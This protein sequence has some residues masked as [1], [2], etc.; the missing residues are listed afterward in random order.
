VKAHVAAA[1]AK[2]HKTFVDVIRK[3]TGKNIGRIPHTYGTAALP[4]AT[5]KELSA[6]NGLS[7][8]RTM[9]FGGMRS[10]HYVDSKGEHLQFQCQQWLGTVDTNVKYA[11]RKPNW[12]PG[13]RLFNKM[14]SPGAFGGAMYQASRDWQNVSFKHIT[15]TYTSACDGLDRGSIYLQYVADPL[16]PAVDTGADEVSHATTNGQMVTTTVYTE[17]PVSLVVQPEKVVKEL[18]LNDPDPSRFSFGGN[19]YVGV[20]DTVLSNLVLGDIIVTYDVEFTNPI[21]SYTVSDEQELEIAVQFNI[22]A[23]SLGTQALEV[24]FGGDQGWPPPA[25]LNGI[26]NGT[27]PEDGV[28]YLVALR[29]IGY[30]D[31]AT[32]TLYWHTPADPTVYPLDA[33]TVLYGALSSTAVNGAVTWDNNSIFM[34]VYGVASP[35]GTYTALGDWQLMVGQ[36]TT[37]QQGTVYFRASFIPG[38]AME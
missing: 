26:L 28:N 32:G 9:K 35:D 8:S 30:D 21:L 29:C 18:A 3:E 15:M 22:A 36:K 6:V 31:S 19:L 25:G 13:E 7:A 24:P 14:L 17:F 34:D 2:S 11:T 4:R 1:V 10:H 5:A 12:G 38:A 27:P 33:G 23:N 37:L 16:L 20:L